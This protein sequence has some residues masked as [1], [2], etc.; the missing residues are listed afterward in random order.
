[1]G[2]AVRFSTKEYTTDWVDLQSG[3]AMGCTISPTLFV[4]AM[5]VILKAAEK[6]AKGP[7]LGEEYHLPPLKAFMDDTTIL[8]TDE[9]QA[10]KMLDRLDDLIKWC[11]M[12]FKPKKSRSLSIS[13][14]KTYKVTFMVSDQVIPTVIEE[15]VKSLGR[16]YDD[17]LKDKKAIKETSDMASN[18]L[19]II[20]RSGL[21]KVQ[22]MVPSIH[23]GSK[24]VVAITN[25]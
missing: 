12:S 14:G 9:D 11:R 10:R 4:T 17:S 16:V 18:G 23:A 1:M 13:K 7:K 24:A 19:Q 2:F 15:P 25:I 3:V 22:N 21:R 6:F 20:D 8:T 5:Q